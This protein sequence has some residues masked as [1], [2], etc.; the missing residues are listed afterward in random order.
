LGAGLSFQKHDQI[1]DAANSAFVSNS[2]EDIKSIAVSHNLTSIPPHLSLYG[3][4]VNEEPS[5]I[6][7]MPTNIFHT[8]MKDETN[9]VSE[10]QPM[11]QALSPSSSPR[12]SSP[13]VYVR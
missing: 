1:V 5:E 11:S 9:C 8:T 10:F 12:N 4:F 3:L 6:I 13:A 2:V 7:E